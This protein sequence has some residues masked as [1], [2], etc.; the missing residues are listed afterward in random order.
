MYSKWQ[1]KQSFMPNIGLNI[2]VTALMT[3][4]LMASL[5]VFIAPILFKTQSLEALSLFNHHR[6]IVVEYFAVTGDWWEQEMSQEQMSCT[7]RVC[8]DKVQDGV[9]SYRIQNGR[10]QKGSYMMSIRPALLKSSSQ[11]TLLLVCGWH[12]PSEAWEIYGENLTSLPRFLTLFP[13]R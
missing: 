2:F 10:D 1:I 11:S 5:S 8:L 9:T 3:I 4:C 12:H 7:H 13:C 6:L